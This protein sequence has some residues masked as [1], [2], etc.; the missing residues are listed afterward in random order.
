MQ[1][2]DLEGICLV[3][4]NDHPTPAYSRKEKA[5]IKI[6]TNLIYPH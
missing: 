3:N 2:I 4:L 1:S 5:K 6:K